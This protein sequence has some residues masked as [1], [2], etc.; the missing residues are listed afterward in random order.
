MPSLLNPSRK[1][2]L[3]IGAGLS[4]M[5]VNKIL[6]QF[7]NASKMAKKLAKK[8]GMKDMQKMIARIN[9]NQGSIPTGIRR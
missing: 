9:G 4:E 1:R 2:R 7:K 8:G 3:A 6:K 5:Q